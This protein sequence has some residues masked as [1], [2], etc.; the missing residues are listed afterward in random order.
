M[1][2]RVLRRRGKELET[3]LGNSE[4][5][6]LVEP[7]I[8]GRVTRSKFQANVVS[9]V[10]KPSTSIVDEKNA[11]KTAKGRVKGGR[12][13]AKAKKTQ[14]TNNAKSPPKGIVVLGTQKE[15]DTIGEVETPQVEKDFSTPLEILSSDIITSTP[16]TNRTVKDQLNNSDISPFADLEISRAFESDLNNENDSGNRT[17][18]VVQAS[19]RGKSVSSLLPIESSTPIALFDSKKN[20]DHIKLADS[21][22]GDE[23][24]DPFGFT[25]AEKRIKTFKK[26][27]P[28]ETKPLTNVSPRVSDTKRDTST[29]FEFNAEEL[30][31]SSPKN[32][33]SKHPKMNRSNQEISRA[34]NDRDENIASTLE[35]ESETESSRKKRHSQPV[36]E[37]A[38]KSADEPE[39]DK[40]LKKRGR[41]KGKTRSYSGRKE[42]GKE[43]AR[44]DD[45]SG[46]VKS[47]VDDDADVAMTEHRKHFMDIDNFELAEEYVY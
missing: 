25:K 17:S 41:G 7:V 1:S 33:K 9:H 30:E 20:S 34:S 43:P 28:S 21:F 45:L 2:R 47:K 32:L 31:D 19:E 22:C 42:K 3:D 35:S 44:G 18:P 36:V 26:T 27:Y 8:T 5:N 23:S 12:G 37:V 13:G 10:E 39:Q 29:S 40:S 38:V 24:E 46:K 14:P 15:K 11:S 6:E 4:K 16:I